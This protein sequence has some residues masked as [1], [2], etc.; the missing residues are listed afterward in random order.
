VLIGL[1][2]VLVSGAPLLARR[3]GPRLAGPRARRVVAR[4]PLV[5]AVVVTLLGA[6]MTVTGLTGLAA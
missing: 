1:G 3:A 2:L 6:V 5:S 4:L